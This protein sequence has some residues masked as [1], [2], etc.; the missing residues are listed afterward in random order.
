MRIERFN[1]EDILL[2]VPTKRSDQRGFFSETY[3]SDVLATE[4][5]RVDFVQ[6]NHVYS[7]E[8]GVLRGLHFQIPP[9][10][11]G[12]LVRCTRGSILDV[13][14]DIRSGSPTYGLHVAVELS[15]ANWGQMWV[16][17]GFAHGYLTLDAHCE[18]IYKVTD[19]WAPAYER[20][21][22]WNDPSLAIDWGISTTD[23][24]LADKDRTNPHLAE[25]EP[26]FHYDR[27]NS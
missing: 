13:S 2:I 7:S 15:A 20:G 9:R 17:P 8:R 1:I 6:D 10:A 19:Y 18:V 11:Q 27:R 21:I 26:V 23:V 5:V 14:V 12:K 25:L 3:R 4:G 24:T 22:A 16:P